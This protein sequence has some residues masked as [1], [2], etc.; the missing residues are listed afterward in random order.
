MLDISSLRCSQSEHQDETS[1]RLHAIGT[2]LVMAMAI[3]N[4]ELL[5]A[6]AL[7]GL[8]LLC[9]LNLCRSLNGD[10]RVSAQGG[11]LAFVFFRHHD[12]GLAEALVALAVFF[13]TTRFL[14]GSL[15]AA[16]AVLVCGYGF[17]WTG[18]FF[19]EGNRPATFV[20]PTFSL[21]CDFLLWFETLTGVSVS[22]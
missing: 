12:H 4:P 9:S 5:A 13:G 18:H 21:V 14:R 2:S 8:W 6:G 15:L 1:V 3:R 20:Y 22:V 7:A 17:A 11:S 10:V 16:L 19:Y